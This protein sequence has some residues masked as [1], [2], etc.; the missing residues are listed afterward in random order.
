MKPLKRPYRLETESTESDHFGPTT[1]ATIDSAE[2]AA[3]RLPYGMRYWIT[4][5]TGKGRETELVLEGIA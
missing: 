3:S 1:Y 4:R 2:N 5:R